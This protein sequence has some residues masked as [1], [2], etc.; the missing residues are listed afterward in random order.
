MK[1]N[2]QIFH[3]NI[4]T[5][6]QQGQIIKNVSGWRP[7]KILS[8]SPLIRTDYTIT[9]TDDK[10]VIYMQQGNIL[11]I[12]KDADF[13]NSNIIQNL[14]QLEKLEWKGEHDQLKQ[15]F[16][17][18]KAYWDGQQTK[19]GGICNK[20]GLK[21]GIWVE[22]W[23]NYWS[24]C[25][26]SFEGCYD[27]NGHRVDNWKYRDEQNTEIGGGYFNNEG[28][29]I[30][31]WKDLHIS[32]NGK[33][34]QSIYIGQYNK[35]V[36][37]GEW[38]INYNQKFIG[39]GFYNEKGHKIGK[40]IEQF[41]G[42][43]GHNQSTFIGKYNTFGMRIGQW[44]IYWQWNGFNKKIGGGQFNDKGYKIGKWVEQ[45]DGFWNYN[46]TTFSGEYNKHGMRIGE[47]E[48]YFLDSFSN[49][50]NNRIGGGQYNE[51]GIKIGRWEELSDQFWSYNQSIYIG[52]Y[53]KQ[54]VKIGEWEIFYKNYNMGNSQK[55][56]GG[57]YDDKGNKTGMWVE[58]ING[59]NYWNQ[60]T[61]RGFYNKQ[62]V[63]EGIWEIF[64]NWNGE[65]QKIGGGYYDEQGRKIG[66]WIEQKDGFDCTQK[67]IL[68]GEYIQGIKQGEWIENKLQ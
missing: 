21:I 52:E 14:E 34:N 66:K 6:Q 5:Q 59:F 4:L 40:W 24:D 68:T 9:F 43:W 28:Q 67:L 25:K 65:N 46:Q 20:K 22:P 64:W 44:E 17:K 33:Q 19:L 61:I 54:G 42:F 11:K 27:E 8:A 15:Q 12:Y 36:R 56:G 47:W 7:S 31:V 10:Q 38:I 3:E 23:D 2:K 18:Y 39:G 30:G 55:I 37:H 60:S 62:G 51:E 29:K 48:I 45:F 41:D 53:N 1:P 26:V 32:Y 63:K 35:G 49:Q 50:P 13:K 16:M 57:Q 58:Q